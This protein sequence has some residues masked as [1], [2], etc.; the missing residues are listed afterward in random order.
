MEM[1]LYSIFRTLPEQLLRPDLCNSD[2][3]SRTTLHVSWHIPCYDPETATF[4]G[5][6]GQRCEAISKCNE[7][8]D[9]WVSLCHLRRIGD[10]CTLYQRVAIHDRLTRTHAASCIRHLNFLLWFQYTPNA[11]N[12]WLDPCWSC[13]VRKS[14]S[15]YE[16]NKNNRINDAHSHSR[17][18][19]SCSSSFYIPAQINSMY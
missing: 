7:N 13:E 5:L 3:P 12:Y 17:T 9:Y 8:E 15:A 4:F 6:C 18:L 14:R 2:S 16:G 11:H 1:Y 19:H 10:C